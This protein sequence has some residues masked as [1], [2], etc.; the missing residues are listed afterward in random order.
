[1]TRTKLLR[2]YAP[3][4]TNAAPTGQIYPRF[5]STLHSTRPNARPRTPLYGLYVSPLSLSWSTLSALSNAPGGSAKE[6]CAARAGRGCASP[7]T[8]VPCNVAV[9][10]EL[11]GGSDQRSVR[12][13]GTYV[14]SPPPVAALQEALDAPAPRYNSTA[15]SS[16]AVA[17][18]ANASSNAPRLFILFGEVSPE[19][20]RCVGGG[21]PTTVIGHR[22][23]SA[24]R[25]RYL[26]LELCGR[27]GRERWRCTWL[28]RRGVESVLYQRKAAIWR[29]KRDSF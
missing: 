25:E 15:T 28:L 14:H 13:A 5:H 22:E 3:S 6:T 2:P 20:F 18:D 23:R 12:R 10:P 24:Q 9:R 29:D 17:R 19:R 7:L 11:V 26:H 1:M 16:S 8:N 4:H 27:S 21:V